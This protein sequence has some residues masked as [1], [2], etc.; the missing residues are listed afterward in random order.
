M[1]ILG[2]RTRKNS[3]ELIT[4]TDF[5]RNHWLKFHAVIIQLSFVGNQ[6]RSCT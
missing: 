3:G 5:D 4:E 6:G 2:T 1:R